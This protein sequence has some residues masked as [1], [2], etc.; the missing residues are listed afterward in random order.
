MK[1]SLGDRMKENYEKPSR[2][3]L[4]RRI[5]AVVRVDGKAFSTFT[6]RA[7]D[8]EKVF[9]PILRASLLQAARSVLRQSQG[10]SVAYIQS[11]EISFLFTDYERHETQ[12][13]FDYNQ[14]KLTSIVASLVSVN[15][16][17]VFSEMRA[18]YVWDFGI[19][20][21]VFDARAFNLPRNE[22]ANYFLWRVKDCTRNS[23]SMYAQS[24]FSHSQLHGKSTADRLEMLEE[25]DM[26][27]E[28]L[29]GW[30]K[31]GSVVWGPFSGDFKYRSFVPSWKVWDDFL[32][33]HVHCD[34]L[35][36]NGSLG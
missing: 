29:L 32:R 4:T 17:E 6:R 35:E 22:V 10:C 31:Y 36:E 26:I 21:P 14:Q 8:T 30:K 27:W 16:W 18:D 2:T 25:R 24:V 15:F 1:D 33:P 12:A 13:W 28:D 19:S 23:I 34:S 9:S 5:P 11:D 20:P 7:C 3:S